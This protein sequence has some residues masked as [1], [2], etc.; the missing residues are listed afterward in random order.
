MNFDVAVL[1][2][3]PGSYTAVIRAAQLSAKVA[4]IERNETTGWVKSIHETRHGEL[5]GLVMVMPSMP[6]YGFSGKPPG[7]GGGP[8]T[9]RAWEELVRRL[10]YTRFVVQGGDWG[11]V[12]ADVMARQAPAELRG[13][14][15]NM[16][17]PCHRT[18][19]RP[20]SVASRRRPTVGGGKNRVRRN[21]CPLKERLRLCPDDSDASAN[22]G[23]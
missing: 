1:G 18:S 23:L 4:C 14:Y 19:R 2:G 3:G 6:G 5:V 8:T 20:S 11:S 9:S 16:L 17:A 12:V 15:V 7:T 13:M 21:A 22:P 10:G